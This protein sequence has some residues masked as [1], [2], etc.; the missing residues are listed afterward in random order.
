LQQLAEELGKARS[1]ISREVLKHRKTSTKGAS[2]R[3][4]NRCVFR[5]D[6][7]VLNLCAEKKVPQEMKRM[8]DLQCRLP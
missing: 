4:A 1:T 6:C 7:D 8:Q 5:R 3:I 2:G